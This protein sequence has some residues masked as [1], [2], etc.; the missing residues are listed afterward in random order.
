MG[1]IRKSESNHDTFH[2]IDKYITS[3]TR[4]KMRS[5]KNNNEQSTQQQ[6]D[7]TISPTNGAND[8]TATKQKEQIPKPE[9][10]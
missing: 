3:A 4:K 1:D 2:I 5:I 8:G 7:E 6:N 9:T 10:V